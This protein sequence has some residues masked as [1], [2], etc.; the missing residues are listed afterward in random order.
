M[1]L[2][3]FSIEIES[4]TVFFLCI[5]Q[6]PSQH[7]VNAHY[8]PIR[9]RMTTNNSIIETTINDL[10][11]L[12]VLS[13]AQLTTQ[14]LKE[15]HLT[16]RI[17][18]QTL[19]GSPVTNVGQ[20]ILYSQLCWNSVNL[21]DDITDV[22]ADAKEIH[23]G[24]IE[25]YKASNYTQ[26]P[27]FKFVVS[28]KMDSI[29]VRSLTLLQSG[30]QMHESWEY[31]KVTDNSMRIILPQF[32]FEF[33]PRGTKEI[34]ESLKSILQIHSIINPKLSTKLEFMH[35]GC[36]KI[37]WEHE[38]VLCPFSYHHLGKYFTNDIN[39]FFNNQDSNSNNYITPPSYRRLAKPQSFCIKQCSRCRW[40]IFYL[41][42]VYPPLKSKTK[43]IGSELQD[44]NIL[45]IGPSNTVPFARDCG[46]ILT[47]NTWAKWDKFNVKL[48]LS[49][50]SS[51]II[52]SQYYL[53]RSED[54][55]IGNSLILVIGFEIDS[56]D[57][58]FTNTVESLRFL[59]N[60]LSHILEENAT[61][62]QS[63]CESLISKLLINQTIMK[64][65][66][67]DSF[68]LRELGNAINSIIVRSKNPEVK[69]DYM[70][71][72]KCE[73]M[74]KTQNVLSECIV[75]L[76]EEHLGS[77]ENK[78]QTKD[79]RSNAFVTSQSKRRITGQAF[80]DLEN[81]DLVDKFEEVSH[82][83]IPES[84]F[85]SHSAP[86]ELSPFSLLANNNLTPK[87]FTHKDSEYS[88]SL[89]KSPLFDTASLPY[90]PSKHG[91][92]YSQN[93]SNLE[94]NALAEHIEFSSPVNMP[95]A[96]Q[97]SNLQHTTL[98]TPKSSNRLITNIDTPTGKLC[99]QNSRT[100]NSQ[101]YRLLCD[102][103]IL[104][105]SSPPYKEL[106]LCEQRSFI[107]NSSQG[108]YE[109]LKNEL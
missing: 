74:E 48:T 107:S 24:W 92:D 9:F 2:G 57:K 99:S 4:E 108:D 59:S 50:H 47:P 16:I 69:A 80:D 40:K 11:N 65:K 61:F 79:K 52:N 23:T 15:A 51:R 82:S 64:S 106:H 19:D 94:F 102:E 35:Q 93:S 18:D 45:L 21:V 43:L 105:L 26:T 66:Q 87:G 103:D 83:R 6:T 58:I 78:T 96:S 77:F 30:V 73:S 53:N 56:S 49:N 84:T 38:R 14:S 62:I 34:F 67:N 104:C 98:C 89:L 28:Y 31:A 101:D 72:L 100:D 81:F 88:N 1:R 12:L 17:S 60:N 10:V 55:A 29:L 109:Q 71:M 3:T 46:P 20:N 42:C 8:L 22:F 91:K 39:C 25:S 7:R 13:S 41:G 76:F 86:N 95:D 33:S 37:E 54:T 27:Q 75:S 90:T 68:L 5:L 63:S 44:V 36:L 70:N 85:Q 97:L 32:P